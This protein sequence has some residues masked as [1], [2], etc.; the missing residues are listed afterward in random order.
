MGVGRQGQVAALK[1]VVFFNLVGCF[2]EV[3]AKNWVIF[4][5]TSQE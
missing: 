5:T 3:Q 1:E 4:G 2:Y